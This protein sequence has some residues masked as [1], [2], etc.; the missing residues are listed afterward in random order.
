L[1]RDGYQHP[2]LHRT[3]PGWLAAF[4]WHP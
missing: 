2:F 1:D 4:A 3:T